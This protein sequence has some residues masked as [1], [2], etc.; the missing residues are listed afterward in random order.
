MSRRAVV[1]GASLGGLLAARAL[2][3]SFDEVVLLDRDVLPSGLRP[4]RQ[5]PQGRH[6]HFVLT[7]G[8]RIIEELFAGITGELVRGGALMG[9]VLRDLH[10]YLGERLILPVESG[11]IGVVASRPLLERTVR[12]RVEA[13]GGVTVA[14]SSTVTGLLTDTARRRVTGVTIASAGRTRAIEDVAL[15]VDAAGRGSRT[16]AWLRALGHEAAPEETVGVGAVYVSQRFR[17]TSMHLDGRLGGVSAPLPDQ[18]R[19]GSVVRQEGG[20]FLVTLHGRHGATP[21]ATR[22]GMLAWAAALPNPDVAEVLRGAEPIGDPSVLRYP[23]A[24]RHHYDLLDRFPDGYLVLG[25]ALCSTNPAAAQGVT[26]AAMQAQLLAQLAG[27]PPVELARRFRA[28]AAALVDDPWALA[29]WHDP[30]FPDADLL[31]ACATEDP[32]AARNLARVLNLTEPISRLSWPH[33]T[34]TASAFA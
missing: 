22:D 10:L 26:L 27:A 17:A 31:A 9:D 15:V 29:A 21:P 7:R 6:A 33:L 5:V 32:E 25:D 11:L 8:S 16:P 13:L 18:D 1:I 4:R 14:G 34:P 30:R 24:Y 3:E 28:S 12:Q 20:T 19:G 23:H 2:R